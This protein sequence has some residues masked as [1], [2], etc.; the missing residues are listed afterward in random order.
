MSDSRKQTGWV[1]QALHILYDFLR[2]HYLAP[3]SPRIVTT[4]QTVIKDVRSVL[5][6]PIAM[7]EVSTVLVVDGAFC[8]ANFFFAQG[9][10][11][12]GM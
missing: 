6:R 4:R 3:S 11:T 5:L 9:S 7:G 2:F 1:L 10:S 8:S 12:V